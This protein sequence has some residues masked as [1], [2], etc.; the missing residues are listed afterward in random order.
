MRVT[1]CCYCLKF[2]NGQLRVLSVFIIALFKM[3]L[4]NLFKEADADAEASALSDSSRNDLENDYSQTKKKSPAN[5]GNS[6]F[7]CKTRKC[8]NK[9]SL[10]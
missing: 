3:F 7:L 9:I 8:L 10:F 6:I 4:I 5:S 2:L 1:K